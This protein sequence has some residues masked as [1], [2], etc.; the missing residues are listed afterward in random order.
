[1]GLTFMNTDKK[2]GGACACIRVC[3]LQ[4]EYSTEQIQW[5]PVPLQD[6][7]SCL[8]LISSRPHGI[9]RILDDQ[10]CLPQATDHTFLQKCHYHHGNSPHYTKPKI[11]LPVFTVYHYAGA[12]TYQVVLAS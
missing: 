4:E 5:Y 7:H 8:D 1:M 10:T 11:P 12:V 6:F 3:V 2:N 9:L